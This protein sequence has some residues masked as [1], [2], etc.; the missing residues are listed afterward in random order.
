MLRSSSTVGTSFAAGQVPGDQ[1]HEEQGGGNEF[2]HIAGQ[3]QQNGDLDTQLI[4]NAADNNG[5]CSPDKADPAEQGRPDDDGR[6]AEYHLA[7]PHRGGKAAPLLADDA[8]GK[9][10]QGVGDH[11]TQDLHAALIH[12]K[13]GHQGVVI[14]HRPQQQ[15]VFGGKIP[16]QH[17]PDQHHQHQRDQQLA[18]Q[19]R[20][21]AQHRHHRGG[22]VDGIHRA[23]HRQ[24][25]AGDLQVDGIQRRHGDD[26]GQQIPHLGPDMDQPGAEP[27]GCP[28]EQRDGQRQPGV[29]PTGQ[30]HGGD[31]SPQRKAAVHRQVREVQD[32]IGDKNAVRQ[33]GVNQ[34]LR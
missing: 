17:Q 22:G 10:H 12:G 3:S 16:L 2:K 1:D 14:P 11:Q 5:S 19:Q 26:A 9:R 29:H 21:A 7:G 13:G 24:V 27:R 25:G 18:V 31:G 4:Q 8:A 15:A 6:Q 23:L 30:Q 34:S 33:N 32:L 28:D 20:H